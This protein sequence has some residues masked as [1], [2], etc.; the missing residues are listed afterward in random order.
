M[1]YLTSIFFS[2]TDSI[3]LSK[4][5]WLIFTLFTLLFRLPY[6]LFSEKRMH[7]DEAF[8]WLSNQNNLDGYDVTLHPFNHDYLGMT[9]FLF[10]IPF[11]PFFGNSGIANQLGLTLVYLLSAFLLVSISENVFSKSVGKLTFFLTLLPSSFIMIMSATYHGGHFTASV[12]GLMAIYFIFQIDSQKGNRNYLYSILVG[13]FFLLSY[14]TSHLNVLMLLVGFPIFFY[15]LVS[16]FKFNLKVLSGLILALAFGCIFGYVPEILGKIYRVVEPT[17]NKDVTVPGFMFAQ[18]NLFVLLKYGIESISGILSH[19][20]MRYYGFQVNK[21][22]G[23]FIKIFAYINLLGFVVGFLTFRLVKGLKDKT[24]KISDNRLIFF[25]FYVILLGGNCLALVA[26]SKNV[27][28]FGIRYLMPVAIFSPIMVAWAWTELASISLILQ[29]IVVTVF[30][31]LTLGG[32]ITGY[33]KPAL[34]TFEG[35]PGSKE[36]YAYFEEKKI[37]FSFS[38]HWLAYNLIK[39]SGQKHLSSPAIELMGGMNYPGLHKKVLDAS[40]KEK[41]A[42][43]QMIGVIP[44]WF[45][46]IKK[47]NLGQYIDIPEGKYR[48]LEESQID[49]WKIYIVESIP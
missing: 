19:P 7:G 42:F 21:N 18:N 43:A 10:T 17:H 28:D 8:L 47:D 26:I 13:F 24:I 27:D 30:F 22:L 15:Q 14:Y 32:Y 6:Y 4:F 3:Y 31:L 9:D 35:S 16:I 5:R 36:V 20:Y 34:Y 33:T 44:A 11:L 40:K 1:K 45:D 46:F 25:I 49:R 39:L 48:I 41:I 12:I 38:N 29:R 23:L 37:H 2:I